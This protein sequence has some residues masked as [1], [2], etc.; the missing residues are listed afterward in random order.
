GPRMPLSRCER[1]GKLLRFERS[2]ETVNRGS[3]R[4]GTSTAVYQ[5]V[6]VNVTVA[7][8]CV[9]VSVA[10]P[11][12]AYGSGVAV[13]PSSPVIVGTASLVGV[14]PVIAWILKN[15]VNPVILNS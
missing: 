13:P 8:H 9:M 7:A 2:A 5:F 4:S 3:A 15:W 10:V 6:E 12:V 14:L 1:F 11:L